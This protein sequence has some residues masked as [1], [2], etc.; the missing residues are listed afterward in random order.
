RE[1][2]ISESAWEE[3]TCLFAPSLIE[4]TNNFLEQQRIFE[5]CK[6]YHALTRRE[7][8][9]FKLA[10]NGLQNKQI[11][12]ELGISEITVKVHRRRVMDKMQVRTLADLVHAA[13][14]L[15]IGKSHCPPRKNY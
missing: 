14:T 8:Q 1:I 12:S 13:G 7:K 11:A 10:I 2:L 4:A 15:Q 6:S 9:I 5:L 3:M